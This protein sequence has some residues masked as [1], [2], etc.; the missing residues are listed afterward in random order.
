MYTCIVMSLVYGI[1]EIVWTILLFWTFG[2][3]QVDRI[4][5]EVGHSR[6]K[7]NFIIE[8]SSLKS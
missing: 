8:Q 3:L 1:F 6:S 7:L 4:G 5:I 2:V